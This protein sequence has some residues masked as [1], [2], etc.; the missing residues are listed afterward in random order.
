ML[1]I[2]HR[3]ACGY[4]PENTLASFKKA[5]D[6]SV[7]IIELDVYVCKS[8]EL[9][10]FHDSKV[11]RTTDGHG[12]V[13]EKTFDELR[14]LNAGQ[15]EKIPLLSEVID[16]VNKQIPI[17]IELK[18]QGT[19]KKVFELIEYY[20][21][22]KD[23]EYSDF[24]IS[25]FNINELE[26]FKSLNSKVET[27]ILMEGNAAGLSEF[28]QQL[29]F[30]SINIGVDFVNKEIVNDAH[31]QGIKV[32]VWTVNEIDYIEKMKNLGVDGIFSNYPDRIN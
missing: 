14:S 13:E 29:G 17:N 32:F 4:A 7:D 20:V 2:G 19:A 5:L 11:D 22:N 9:V 1:K 24:I 15:G 31:I 12:F 18:G 30:K 25:S 23:W 6:L 10:V 21:N 8:G 16:L 26:I 3:G 27:G 28:A